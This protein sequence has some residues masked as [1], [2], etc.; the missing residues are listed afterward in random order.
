MDVQRRYWQEFVDLKRN[1]FYIDLYHAKVERVD[2]TLGMFSAIASSASIG[3]WAIWRDVAG[4][5]AL[6][7][8]LSQVLSA[9]K[10]YLPY[11]S[12]LRGLGSLGKDLNALALSAENDWFKV[13]Q[14]FLTEQQIHEL[15]MVLKGKIQAATNNGFPNSSLPED[16]FL[17]EKA[18]AAVQLYVQR[19]FGQE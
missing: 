3:A 5:W 14:G 12:R 15:Q 10:E 11:K 7:I 4:L 9:I 16:K 18:E 19:F 17:L 8:A 6:V 1:A 2:R 13:S